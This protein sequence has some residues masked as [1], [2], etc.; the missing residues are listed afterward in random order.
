MELNGKKY[1]KIMDFIR[2]TGLTRITIKRYINQN[3]LHG[4]QI[5]RKYFIDEEDLLKIGR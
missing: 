2:L 5:G 1:L 4:F 3:I